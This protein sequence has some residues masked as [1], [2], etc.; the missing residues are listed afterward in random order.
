MSDDGT[1]PIGR[2]DDTRPIVGDDDPRPI[3][4]GEDPTRPI[5]VGAAAPAAAATADG[6]TTPVPGPPARPAGHIRVISASDEPT[7][8]APVAQRVGTVVWGLV[9][10]AI[11]VGL[12]SV[13]W[14][15]HLDA[16]LALIVLLGVAGAALLVGSLVGLRRSRVPKEGHA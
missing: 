8:P 14:N 16:E 4:A 6:P 2:D 7:Q 10:A 12:L 3:P 9:V 13:A 11:G 1:R 5:P 15:A